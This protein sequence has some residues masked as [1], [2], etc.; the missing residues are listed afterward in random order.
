MLRVG[1]DALAIHAPDRYIELDDLAAARGVD[2]AKYRLGLGGR[3]MAVVGPGEDTVALAAL[4]LARL[5][6]RGGVDPARIGMLIVGTETGV[7]H[8]KPVASYVQGLL[9]LPSSMRT[10]DLQHACFGGTA[11]LMTAAQWIASGAARDRIAVVICSDIARYP[12]GSAGEPTQGAGAV[13]MSI[14]DSPRLLELDFGISGAFSADVHDFWRPH[15]RKEAVVDGHYSVGCYL[16]AL[17]GAYR[18]WRTLA[19]EQGLIVRSDRLPS[20]QL[21][22]IAYHVPFC[23]MAK[24]AHARVRACDLEDLGGGGDPNDDASFE[25]QVAPS[26]AL[27]AELGNTYTAS[28]YLALAG[29]ARV[30]STTRIG[31]FSYGSGCAAEFFSGVLGDGARERV[32]GAEMLDS[33]ERVSVAEYERLVY[34]D[35]EP[36][37]AP[38]RYRYAGTR[39]HRRIYEAG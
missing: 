6:D 21:D 9:K 22:A 4:A 31:L 1:I 37:P 8:S 12:L 32:I 33:R 15:G 10:F 16:D 11:G 36:A 25:H 24:K 29:L 39:D 20:E 28:L 2:P 27:P 13:A 23:K 14:Q 7:D 18:A 38:G 26:L 19:W 34:G 17:G 35:L 3:R 30:G 5:I